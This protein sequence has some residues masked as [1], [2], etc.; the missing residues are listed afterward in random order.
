MKNFFRLFLVINPIIF[1]EYACQKEVSYKQI[2]NPK[3]TI[4]IYQDTGNLGYLTI[5]KDTSFRGKILDGHGSILRTTNNA[6]IKNVIL[7]NWIIDGPLTIQMFDTTVDLQ[8]CVPYG[9]RFSVA[10]FGASPLRKD[11]YDYLQKS[12]NTCLNNGIWYCFIPA[13]KGKEYTYSKPLSVESIY[14]GKYVGCSLKL[15]GE[16]NFW[17]SWTSTLRYTGLSSSALNFQLNKGSQVESL[18]IVGEWKSPISDDATY[19]PRNEDTYKDISGKN[20]GKNLYG[21]TIDGKV[22]LNGSRSGSTGISFEDITVTNFAILISLSPNAITAND[23]IMRFKD[24]HLGDGFIGIQNNQAQE[25]DIRFDGIY[26]WGNLYCLISIGKSGKYQAGDYAFSNANI[27]GRV[28]KVFDISAS[29]WYST[30]ID[31]FY[32][33]S[34]REIGTIN[35]QV[36]I[37]ISNSTFHL[38][39][40]IDKKRIVLWGNSPLIKI[41]SSI[42]GYYDGSGSDVWVSGQM[43]FENCDFR[44]GKLI[45][46]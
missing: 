1:L 25:K 29:G 13:F 31:N 37:T 6:V 26:A 18:K 45:F 12:I 38:N 5:D 33:E 20:I 14:K 39:Y 11:N 40:N 28:I 16:G 24:T 41:S 4:Y 23:D 2:I 44:I 30:H 10:W 7:K 43:T 32:V 8:N 35:T 15:G 19:F 36:P 42:V 34:I 46:K 27:A 17:T 22:P 3:D 21:I 9:D